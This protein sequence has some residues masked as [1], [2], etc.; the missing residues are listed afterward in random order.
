MHLLEEIK[1]FLKC[2][3]E[4]STPLVTGEDGLICTTKPQNKLLR[5]FTRICLNTMQKAKQIVI[6][7]GEES[8]DIHA[9]VLIKQL[10]ATYPDIKISG[11]GGRHMQEAGA[12]LI[13]DLARFG[14]TGFTEVIRHLKVIRKAFNAIK[15]HLRD[16]KTGFTYSGRLSWF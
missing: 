8:G 9:S 2:I 11:I 7:A 1:A 16:A 5:L 4:D 13:S 15:K 12:E 14:V 3:E 10:K 6:I